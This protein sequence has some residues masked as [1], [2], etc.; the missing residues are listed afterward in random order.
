MCQRQTLTT[1]LG[2]GLS[3]LC[4]MWLAAPLHAADMPTRIG[5]FVAME[6]TASMTLPAPA[7]ADTTAAHRLEVTRLWYVN[8]ATGEYV[9]TYNHYV[10]HYGKELE[11]IIVDMLEGHTPEIAIT[12]DT[13]IITYHAGGNAVLYKRYRLHEGQVHIVIEG[14]VDDM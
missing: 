8:A 14:H 7:H 4:V 10:V 9:P 5:G 2:T 3:M 13:I 11:P 12:R 1:T 6:P